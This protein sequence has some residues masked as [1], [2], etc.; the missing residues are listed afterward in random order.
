MKK[1][2]NWNK[3]VRVALIKIIGRGLSSDMSQDKWGQLCDGI[4]QNKPNDKKRNKKLKQETR[5]TRT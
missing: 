1:K 4:E 5:E 2:K 3:T